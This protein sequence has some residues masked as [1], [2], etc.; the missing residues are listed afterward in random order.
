MLFNERY[1]DVV[2]RGEFIDTGS[3]VRVVAVYQN[4]IVV[5]A[6]TAS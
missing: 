4:R 5:S 2:T 6:T 3:P 1:F